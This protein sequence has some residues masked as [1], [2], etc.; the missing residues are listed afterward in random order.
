MNRSDVHRILLDSLLPSEVTQDTQAAENSVHEFVKQA[1][2]VLEPENALRDN[3]HIELVC[4]Y[5]Q[6]VSLGQIKRL[7]INE[8][9]RHSKSTVCTILWPVHSWITKPA[10]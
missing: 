8:P 6:A 7:I 9:P 2:H 1:W 5:L 4:E 3:W 10:L